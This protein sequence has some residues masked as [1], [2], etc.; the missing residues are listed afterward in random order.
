MNENK[1]TGPDGLRL[2][3]SMS[4]DKLNS[5]GYFNQKYL[6]P[7]NTEEI[8]I[9]LLENVSSVAVE[10]FKSQS[11]QV[12]FHP[13]ALSEEVLKEKIKDVHAIGI[14]FVI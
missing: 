11:Y 2:T 10:A 4:A 12:E 5:S 8:K 3:R 14:R 7:F 1:E 6:K 9:L 13:K